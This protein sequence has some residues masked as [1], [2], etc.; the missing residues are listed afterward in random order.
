MLNVTKELTAL[1]RKLGYTGKAPDTVAKAINAITSVAG[2]GGGGD[3][4]D[5]EPGYEVVETQLF[6]ETVTTG[7][8]GEAQFP[9]AILTYT[10]LI[11]AP[12]LTVTFDDS[13]YTVP[14]AIKTSQG[15]M[16]GDKELDFSTYPFFIISAS[17]PNNPNQIANVIHTKTAGTYN[18][19]VSAED[20]SVSNDFVDAVNASITIPVLRVVKRQ[21]TWQEVYDAIKSGKIAYYVEDARDDETVNFYLALHTYVDGQGRYTVDF[22]HHTGDAEISISTTQFTANSPTDVL[23]AK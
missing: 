1:A 15:N 20:I 8:V 9:G 12:S 14:L 7:P 22:L 4:C 6:N 19:A 21:T 17:N 10:S 18:V 23:D 13:T 11:E 16:Y 3:G 5:C 2:E